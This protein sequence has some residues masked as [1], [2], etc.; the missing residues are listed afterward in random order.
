[1]VAKPK[2]RPRKYAEY[3]Q[4]VR[5]LPK[6]MAK[7]PKY[8]KGIGVFRGARGQTAW[9]K[10]RLPNGGIHGGRSYSPGTRLEIKLGNLSSWTWEQLESRY[11][12]L[13][14][15]ADRG[16]PLE[17]VPS[18]LFKDWA[19]NWLVRAEARLRGA[20]TVKY[21]INRQ[22]LPKFGKKTLAGINTADVNNW[23]SSRLGEVKPSTVKRE[24]STLSSILGAAVKSGNLE[25]NPCTKAD[26]IKGVTGRQRFLDQSELV[27]LL[28]CAEN[29]SSQWLSDFI[30]WAVHSGMRKGE[31]MGLEWKDIQTLQDDKTIANIKTSKSDQG[32]MVVCTETMKQ[33][34][35]RQKARKKDDRVFPI[36]DITLRRHWK[37]ARKVAELED[38]T[39][40]DLRRTH[41]TH[42]AA[43]GVDLRTLA[44]RIG[45][46]DLTMLQKHYAVLVGSAS[47]E[48]AEKI[49]E[50][51]AQ[52]ARKSPENKRGEALPFSPSET[53]HRE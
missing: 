37:K 12:E 25:E 27:T 18:V 29:V 30:L 9:V 53:P 13:Q 20:D 10:I 11:R 43:S 45:H 19:E 28:A 49:E 32:R 3:E 17:D 14:G 4:L 44:G 40:H 6:P 1:M 39:I 42:A 22:L 47:E 5:S 35:K 24:L 15:K 51:F 31:V 23:S 41:S 8:L 26:P 38:V 16:E 34:L 21:H 50:D 2:G 7:R 33:V 36:A 48:A 52:G 46:S